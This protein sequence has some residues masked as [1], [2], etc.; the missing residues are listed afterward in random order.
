MF[1][2]CQLSTA[3]Y[4]AALIAWS[5][6][7]VQSGVRLDVPLSQYSAGAATTARGVLTSAPN[8]WTI[9]DGGQL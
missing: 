6:Q 1:A 7:N 8:N 9:I 2:G 4:D 3:S 5:Q